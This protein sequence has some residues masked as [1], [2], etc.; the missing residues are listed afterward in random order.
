MFEINGQNFDAANMVGSRIG[1]ITDYVTESV[2]SRTC[3]TFNGTTGGAAYLGWNYPEKVS[4]TVSLSTDDPLRACVVDAE[5]C[6]SLLDTA[7]DWTANVGNFFISDASNAGGITLTLIASMSSATC[8]LI[9]RYTRI[10]VDYD[11]TLGTVTAGTTFYHLL[12]HMYRDLTKVWW[13]GVAK[14]DVT[15][16]GT[17]YDGLFPHT[18]GLLWQYPLKC[19]VAWDYVRFGGENQSYTATLGVSETNGHPDNGTLYFIK[20]ADLAAAILAGT[21]FEKAIADGAFT[22]PAVDGTYLVVKIGSTGESEA[23]VLTRSSGNW[24]EDTL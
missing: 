19:M 8:S 20:A 23:Q 24:T 15:H 11:L 3:I 17:S 6:F 12:L 22:P 13:D 9:L 14:A 18:L 2:G 7:T 10:G 4:G 1:P 16:T 5:I 21:S